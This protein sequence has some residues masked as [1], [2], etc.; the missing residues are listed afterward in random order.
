MDLREEGCSSSDQGPLAG[1][2]CNEGSD[3]ITGEK[4]RNQLSDFAAL[5]SSLVIRYFRR[6]FNMK[7]CCVCPI[8]SASL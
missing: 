8:W 3:A 4:F 1:D 5:W 7:L 2:Y 6:E